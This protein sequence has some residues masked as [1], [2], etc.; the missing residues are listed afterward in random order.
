M[1]QTSRFGVS[2][3][4]ALLDRFDKLIQSQGYASRSEAIRDLVREALVQH[5]WQADNVRTVGTVCLVYD[6]SASDLSQKLNRVQHDS[7][8]R[9]IASLHVH[10]D[11]HNCLEIVVLRGR[12]SQ[13][14]KLADQ[15]KSLRGVKHAQLVMGTTGK[16]L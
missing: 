8:E 13:I 10:L 11:E 6:H 16:K 14:K 9:V 3:D 12:P 5:E 1:D 4:Q 7:P 15:L 2:M